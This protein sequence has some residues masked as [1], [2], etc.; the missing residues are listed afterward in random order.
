MAIRV[1]LDSNFLMM[2]TKFRIDILEWL[3]E[4]LGQ[5]ADAVVLSPIYGELKRIS[6]ARNPKEAMQARDALRT[7]NQLEIIEVENR[8]NETVDELILR[9]AS[10]W[11]CIVAT[12][13]S[14]LR[15]RLKKKNI[16]VIYLRQRRKLEANRTI[17]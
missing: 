8:P 6:K 1:I 9:Q 5:R 17:L 11:N 16:Q 3:Q 13:D 2:H 4:V 7:A 14:E 10:E 15:K 12:N